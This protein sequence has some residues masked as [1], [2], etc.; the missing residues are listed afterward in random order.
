MKTVRWKR[1]FKRG[2]GYA[3]IGLLAG[4][5]LFE[6]YVMARLYLFA[7]CHIPT[8]SMTPAL[9]GGDYIIVSLRIP[10][11][12][13]WQA[14][15]GGRYTIER[16][17]GVREV[18]VGD[19][20]VFNFPYARDGEKMILCNDVYYCKRCVALPGQEYRWQDFGRERTIR[21][22]AK[23]ETFALDSTNL[24]D[25]R[26][27][28]EYETQKQVSWRNDSVW[29]G[30]SLISRYRFRHDYYFM[31]GDNV[32]DSYDSRFW[33]MLPE[34]FILGVGK[35]IWFSC[36]QETGEIRWERIFRNIG[37]N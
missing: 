36:Q 14:D 20:V 15:E 30:D 29:L 3:G 4:L 7:S 21:L 2:L 5:L 25:Y 18:R 9:V 10:G 35:F 17:P 1:T 11:R 28:I 16:K 12:R 8:G 23:G 34:D 6:L 26:K 22:P 19:V 32:N 37:Q 24:P 13:V 33:G 27:C 31:R